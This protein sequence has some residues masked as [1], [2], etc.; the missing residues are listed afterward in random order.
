MAFVTSWSRHSTFGLRW[1]A[2]VAGAIHLTGQFLA[3]DGGITSVAVRHNSHEIW[4]I[5]DSGKFDLTITFV[6]E[7]TIDFVVYGGYGYGN[8][9]INA[10]IS[11]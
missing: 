9:P 4:T 5:S 1:I 11:Y 3:G 10:N 7:D 6:A 8:T 2:P